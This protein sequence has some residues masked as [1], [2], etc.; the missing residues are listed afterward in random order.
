MYWLVLFSGTPEFVAGAIVVDFNHFHGGYGSNGVHYVLQALRLQG[1]PV[2]RTSPALPS[3]G[4]PDVHVRPGQLVLIDAMSPVSPV[5]PG[6]D[7]ARTTGA[8]RSSLA[9]PDVLGVLDGL[10]MVRVHAVLDTAE[11][12]DHVA[13]GDRALGVLVC[14]AVGEDGGFGD[15]EFAVAESCGACPEPARLGLVDLV[16]E[17]F[18]ALSIPGLSWSAPEPVKLRA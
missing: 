6:P 17:A 14:P 15:L 5:V 3:P 11:V 8:P 9:T 1:H 4:W 18:H 16:P 7:A 13:G 10:E 2:R 12:V